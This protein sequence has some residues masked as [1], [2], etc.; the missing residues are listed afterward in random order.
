LIILLVLAA[1]VTAAPIAATL[2]V[3]FASLR[4]DAEQSFPG[5]PPGPLTAAARR[6][7]GASS[8]RSASKPFRPLRRRHAP[9]R[10]A[11]ARTLTGPHA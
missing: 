5:R 3:T 2:L 10:D 11:H 8:R 4:E 9:K 1:V 6:L 7:L